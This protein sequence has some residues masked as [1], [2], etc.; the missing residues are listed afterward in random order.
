MTWLNFV[1]I[2]LFGL[3]YGG[4]SPGCQVSQ[5]YTAICAQETQHNTSPAFEFATTPGG[6]ATPQPIFFLTRFLGILEVM[7]NLGR[8]IVGLKP[9]PDDI[10]IARSRQL[11]WLGT[12][13]RGWFALFQVDYHESAICFFV[14][15]TLSAV[16]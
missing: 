3:I 6:K 8:A 5:E 10:S 16:S 14:P 7:I 4:F 9:V 15:L 2:L 13:Q 11:T 12:L 1:I